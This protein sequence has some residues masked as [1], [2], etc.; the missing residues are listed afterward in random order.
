M[1]QQTEP[2]FQTA[3]LD[4]FLFQPHVNWSIGEAKD[5]Y[6]AFHREEEIPYPL[7][8]L[9]IDGNW[10]EWLDVH[11]HW[12]RKGYATELVKALESRGIALEMTG[13]TDEGEAFVDS[14]CGPDE[15]EETKG[16]PS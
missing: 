9:T 8:T 7:A 5:V 2:L 13:G 14:I 10:I 12:R 4:V 6:I 11:P 1:D 3:R 16:T 15:Q